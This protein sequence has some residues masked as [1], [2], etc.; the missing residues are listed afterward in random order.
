MNDHFSK[1]WLKVSVPNPECIY[2]ITNNIM[3]YDHTP[4]LTNERGL[5]AQNIR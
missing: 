4:T 5:K 3:Q 2:K 1:F